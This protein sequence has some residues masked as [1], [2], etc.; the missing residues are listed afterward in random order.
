MEDSR[1]ISQFKFRNKEPIFIIVTKKERNVPENVEP[2]IVG[3]I[4][5]SDIPQF[6]QDL[7][8]KNYNFVAEAGLSNQVSGVGTG[9]AV[10]M[11]E[12]Q[13]G[14]VDLKVRFKVQLQQ[15]KEIGIEDQNLILATLAQTGGN[16][17]T[18]IDKLFNELM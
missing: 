7:K 5:L 1:K 13:R 11:Q 2:L 9:N 8:K 4:D 10:R 18:A 15:I 12:Q 16:V 17:Q 6:S 14:E 3:G